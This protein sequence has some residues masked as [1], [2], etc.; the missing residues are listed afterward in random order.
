M[1]ILSIEHHLQLPARYFYQHEVDGITGAH[2][3]IDHL[4]FLNKKL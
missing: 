2:P 3:A 4:L 1:S